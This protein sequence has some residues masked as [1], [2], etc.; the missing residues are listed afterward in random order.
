MRFTLALWVLLSAGAILTTD[1]VFGGVAEGTTITVTKT[2]G[3][4]D[5]GCNSDCS[6]REAIT[7]DSS[8]DT[9]IIPSA[10]YTLTGA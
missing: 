2:A 4:N 5:G 3:T 10:T 1:W 8:G 9:I 7:V 6:L